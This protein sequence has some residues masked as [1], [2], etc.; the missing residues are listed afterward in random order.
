MDPCP[1]GGRRFFCAFNLL[2]L[3]AIHAAPVDL[4]KKKS[5]TDPTFGSQER[6]PGF[7]RGTDF[8]LTAPAS[9]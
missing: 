9:R 1:S 4:K 2:V 7:I 3:F 6:S 8:A 5:H